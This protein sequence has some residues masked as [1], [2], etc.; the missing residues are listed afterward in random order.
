MTIFP[1]RRE[2]PPICR[3]TSG[4]IAKLM[5]ATLTVII[6][7]GCAGNMQAII[8]GEGTPVVFSF[9]QGF[10]SDFYS[11][12]IDGERFTGRRC[13][14]RRQ[15]GVLLFVRIWCLSEWKF[16]RHYRKFQSNTARGPRF[17]AQMSY[18]IC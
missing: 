5:F 12:E 3:T 18:A 7:G 1:L 4:M 10:S 16:L 6:A 14:G 2:A 15:F 9:E 11:A 17:H 8:R 13:D